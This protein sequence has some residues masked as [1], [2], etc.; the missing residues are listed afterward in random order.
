VLHDRVSLSTPVR[1][2]ADDDV[3]AVWLTEGT[4][5]SFPAHPFGPHPWAARRRW[6]GTNV[7][8]LHR[9]GDAHAVW[10]SFHG[11]RL[12]YWYVNFLPWP[13]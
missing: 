7:L 2:V 9:P 5:L 13:D 8:Q 11:A 4:P 3:L 10:A 12:D 1:V 6:S